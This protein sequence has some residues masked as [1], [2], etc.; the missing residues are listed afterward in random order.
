[1]GNFS[2]QKGHIFS[3]LKMEVLT[4]DNIQDAVRL[5]CDNKDNAIE[6]YGYINEWDVSRVTDMS[7]LFENKLDARG[8]SSQL[9]I[10]G[11]KWT[12][13]ARFQLCMKKWS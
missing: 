8:D 6:I 7:R 9:K 12:F 4:N 5:W 2:N 13:W 1:M 11:Q 10:G 3:P